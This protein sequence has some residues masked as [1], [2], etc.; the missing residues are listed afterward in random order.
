MNMTGH[1]TF[2]NATVLGTYDDLAKSDKVIFNEAKKDLKG[3]LTEMVS[4]WGQRGVDAQ[5]DYNEHPSALGVA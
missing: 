5:K 3:E 1:A 2:N 4:I